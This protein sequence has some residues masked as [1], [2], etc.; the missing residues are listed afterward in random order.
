MIRAVVFDLWNTLVL[1]RHGDPFR[2]IQ[3]LLAPAQAPLFDALRRDAMGRAHPSARTFLDAWRDRLALDAGQLD[4]MAAL[5]RAAASDAQCFPEALQ[6]VTDTRKL[7]RVALLSN[8]Q[9]FDL[10]F[11][12][13]LG[14]TSLLATRMLSAEMGCL[15]PDRQA[16]ETV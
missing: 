15:K 11:L 14:L 3:R 16:F 8:T 5:F 4:T 13:R 1:S 7:A 10:D 2:H 12:E 9:S 6:A